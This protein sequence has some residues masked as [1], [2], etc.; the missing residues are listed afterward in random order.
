MSVIT[1]PATL[2]IARLSWSQIRG[3]LSFSSLFGS[4]AVEV[5]S[6]LWDVQLVGTPLKHSQAGDWQ[7]LLMNLRGQTNQLALWNDARAYPLGTMRGTMAL[8]GAHAQG[9]TTLNILA[10]SEAAKTL[11][12][13]DYL[14]LGSGLTQQVVM[15]TADATADGTGLIAV[16]VEPP[17]R[18]AFVDTSTVTW[19]KPMALFRRK[20]S[21]AGWEYVPGS[22]SGFSLDLIED[23]RP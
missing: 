10:G 13:G 7:A 15:V 17:L 11:L 8:S 20:Q 3:D 22:V 14:G 1:F 9:A 12:S 6:P 2:G 19:D 23:W 18:N 4:Q 21:T 5:A 16:T